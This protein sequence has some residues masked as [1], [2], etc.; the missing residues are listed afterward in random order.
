MVVNDYKFWNHDSAK[1]YYSGAS[2]SSYDCGMLLQRYDGVPIRI[3][4]SRFYL[5]AESR[6]EISLQ[7]D[8]LLYGGFPSLCKSTIKD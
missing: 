3:H 8:S 4:D 6:I 2:C 1:F 7:N 5:A